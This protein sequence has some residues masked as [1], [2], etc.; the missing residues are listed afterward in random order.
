MA[1]QFATPAPR[2]G[3]PV[4][5][6][7]LAGLCL[8]GMVVGAVLALNPPEIPQG[9]PKRLQKGVPDPLSIEFPPPGSD[10]VP[11]NDTAPRSASGTPTATGG[12]AGP[13]S[14]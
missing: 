14:R 3:R 9:G 7:A 11:Q 4:G 10:P 1:E 8:A 2:S 5:T 6:L 13:R 12:A